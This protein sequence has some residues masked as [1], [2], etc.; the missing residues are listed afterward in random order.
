MSKNKKDFFV[1]SL[2]G[3]EFFDYIRSKSR[4]AR[5][6]ESKVFADNGISRFWIRTG[7]EVRKYLCIVF[8]SIHKKKNKKINP[9]IVADKKLK[10]EI[11]KQVQND[12]QKLPPM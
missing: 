11:L 8:W 3:D 10:N 9:P 2:S 12:Q 7:F 6:I 5:E 1:G 4:E